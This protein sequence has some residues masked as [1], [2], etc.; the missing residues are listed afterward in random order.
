VAPATPFG[1]NAAAAIDN[2]TVDHGPSNF[3]IATAGSLTAAPTVSSPVTLTGGTDGASGVT[4]AILIGQD[5]LPRKGMYVFR[6][7]MM[8]SFTLCDLSGRS[9]SA[10]MVS[11]SLC[12]VADRAHTL[13]SD[14]ERHRI[15]PVSTFKQIIDVQVAWGGGAVQPCHIY[16]ISSRH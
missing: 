9:R 7:S 13:F 4:D 10:D 1:V 15:I 11:G 12:M 6:N 14:S 8:D 3:V 5:V 16:F 2:G